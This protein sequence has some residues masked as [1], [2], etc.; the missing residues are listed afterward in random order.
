MLSFIKRHIFIIIVFIFTLIVSFITFLTFIGKN[1]ILVNDTNL[2]YLLFTNISLLLF[3]FIIIFKE[4]LNSIKSNI[5]VRGSIANRKYIIFFSLFTLI[6]SLLISIFSLF[7]F[8]FAL[9]KYFDSKI[10]LAVN[11]SYE[12]AKNYVDEKRNKVESDIVLVSYDLNRNVNLFKNN[13]NV[14]QNFLNTQRLLRGLDQ[15]HIIDRDRNVLFSSTETG[16]LKVEERALNMVLNDDKPLKIIN[17][18]ENKSAAIIKI[19]SMNNAFL[20][21]V[22]FLDENIS[23]YLKES[24]EAINFYYTVE[25]QRTGIK[26][27]FALI[28]IIIVTLLLFLSITIAV[29]FSSRFFV[30]INNLISAS[31]KIG[32]GNLNT[33]VPEIVADKEIEL[34]NKNFNSMINQ[35]KFQQEKLLISERHEAWEHVAR[36]LAHEI[37]NPLTPIQLTIDNLKSKYE[38]YIDTNE[39]EKYGKN[40]TTILTQIKQIEHL[41]NEFS[42]FARMP[43]PLFRNNNLVELIN[44]NID[45]LKKTDESIKINFNFPNNDDLNLNC[46][47]EQ[48]SRAIFNL[49]KNSIE[50]IQEKAVNIGN[51]DKKINIE[52]KRINHYITINIF[53]NGIG[54]T[55]S[56]KKELI[57]PYYTTKKK[58]SGL[59]LSIVNKII[60][61]HNGNIEFNS[62]SKGTNV[63]INLP[64][65]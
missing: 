33:K 3:F 36:K 64:R 43:K 28:Y 24:E 29:R 63:I 61:D 1:F 53:D 48:I 46:D 7:I 14:L 57:K 59:G 21:V 8:S 25:N 27:S 32:E 50:S 19:Q 20:Y 13:V 58:G 31:K 52:I 40:L 54:F 18:Y 45:L 55:N 6:P 42:E 47:Y 65:N 62:D 37:K 38:K 11:N 41:V 10:T 12:L 4:I 9:E 22:K 49:I 35:L 5:N 51:F 2:D 17:A 23:N 56:T 15:I 34:L 39:K 26:Y 16:Y 60:N 44:S 30:S